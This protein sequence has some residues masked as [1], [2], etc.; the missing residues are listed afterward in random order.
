MERSIFFFICNPCNLCLIRIFNN[1]IIQE[2]NEIFVTIS[3]REILVN[4]TGK[5]RFRVKSDYCIIFTPYCYVII[6]TY[7]CHKF[8]CLGHSAI[9]KITNNCQRVD[10]YPHQNVLYLINVRKKYWFA[11]IYLDKKVAFRLSSS[12]WP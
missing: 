8:K 9:I 12:L 10:C 11:F 7:I 4:L 2:I 1:T 6:G 3:F 5:K